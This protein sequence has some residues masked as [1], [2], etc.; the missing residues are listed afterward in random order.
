MEISC[1]NAYQEENVNVNGF[2]DQW[3][4]GREPGPKCNRRFRMFSYQQR[5]KAVKLLVQINIQARQ[6]VE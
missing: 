6:L 5:I 4:C 3:G 2:G 1:S